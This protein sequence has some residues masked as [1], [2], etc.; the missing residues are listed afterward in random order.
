MFNI[1]PFKKRFL[2]N[3]FNVHFLRAVLYALTGNRI[4]TV[5][6]E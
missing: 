4:P 1:E 5:V 3:M 2:S 6:G